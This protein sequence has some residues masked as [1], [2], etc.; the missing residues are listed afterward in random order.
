MHQSALVTG[1]ARRVGAALSRVLA[2]NGHFV[3]IHYQSSAA[4]AASLAE[5][6]R[7]AGGACGLIQ[8]DL[9]DRAAIA[10]LVPRC[11]EAFGPIGILV[12]NASGYRYDTIGTLDTGPWDENVRTNLEAPLFL[13]Q[14]FA[15]TRGEQGGAIVNLLDFKV[16]NLNPDFFSYTVA[17][18][19][20]AGATRMLAMAYEGRVRVNGVAPG[21]TLISGKQ[22]Q[23]GFE[24]AWTAPPLGRSSTPKEVADA[25]LWLASEESSFVN[26]VALPVDGATAV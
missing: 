1:G 9:N 26:G 2:A 24:R 14:A 23:A 6:I 10:G 5:E 19:G 13:A 18:I 8:A 25:V 11:I 21:I 7:A 22:T 3:A 17:K 4:E 20:L 15:R 16:T 12:N